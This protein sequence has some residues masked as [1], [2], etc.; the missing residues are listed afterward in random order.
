MTIAPKYKTLA[1]EMQTA[2]LT[3]DQLD[4]HLMGELDGAP[5]AHL[6]ACSHCTARVAE[7]D[8]PL[9][10]FRAVTMAWSERQSATAPIPTVAAAARSVWERRL[11]WSLAA[12]TCAILGVAGA[13]HRVSLSAP[14]PQPVLSQEAAAPSA[15]QL[16]SDNRL[17]NSIDRELNASN[18]SPDALGLV[19]VSSAQ[20]RATRVALFRTAVQD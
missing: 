2:H 18:E 7:F 12:A 3:E 1:H 15:D 13:N 17:L 6:A 16:S 9:A 19:P 20:P 10:S 4:D 5:A 11:A 14:A 8:A